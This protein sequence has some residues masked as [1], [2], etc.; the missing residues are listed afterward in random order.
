[1]DGGTVF[2][3]SY[4]AAMAEQGIVLERLKTREEKWLAEQRA[5]WEKLHRTRMN[6]EQFAHWCVT[7]PG[8]CEC[9]SNLRRILEKL[10]PRYEEWDRFSWELHNAV[11]HHLLKPELSWQ[12]ACQLW[13]WDPVPG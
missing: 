1:M 4:I 8:A 7:V 2:P 3:E 13:G 5:H 9:Q 10:P 11:N 12:E 6:A